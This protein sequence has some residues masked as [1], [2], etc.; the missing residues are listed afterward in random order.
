MKNIL[1]DISDN[2]IWIAD[3]HIWG[4]DPKISA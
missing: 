1:A 3:N 2:P 4:H